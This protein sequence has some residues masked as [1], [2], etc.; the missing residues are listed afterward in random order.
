MVAAYKTTYGKV[1]WVVF[2]T[3]I[4]LWWIT[5]HFH[6][7]FGL[8]WFCFV[9][10]GSWSE[11]RADWKL[12]ESGP[13]HDDEPCSNGCIG[14]QRGHK[15]LKLAAF[16]LRFVSQTSVWAS[17]DRESARSCA[18]YTVCQWS[19]CL[20]QVFRLLI[21]L[22]PGSRNWWSLSD[23][24]S[25]IALQCRDPRNQ[26][27]LQSRCVPPQQRLTLSTL[28]TRKSVAWVSVIAGCNDCFVFFSFN[29]TLPEYGKKLE[30][31]ISSDTS[32]HFRRLLVSLCQVA[33]ARFTP[34]DWIQ[35]QSH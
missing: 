9:G 32:G 20:R 27:N 22:F 5:L 17:S 7:P 34:D 33:A 21:P 30:D 28:V 10:S 18:R 4:G 13:L 25:F 24:D 3:L 29:A 31:A 23:W 19:R 35:S 11:V 15:G 8:P 16:T 2:C 12:R 1:C 26:Q 14:T 6:F